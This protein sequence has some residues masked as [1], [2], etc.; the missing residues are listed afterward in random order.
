VHYSLFADGFALWMV[1]LTAILVTS[2]IWIGK[3]CA[4][5]RYKGFAAL[6]FLLEGALF[7]CFL[8]SDAVL[9]FL[10]FELLVPPAALLI[11]VFG[12]AGR[13]RAA[14]LF[15]LYTLLGSAPMAIALWALA[16]WT[17]TT[18]GMQ[19]ATALAAI[20]PEKV[21]LLFFAFALAFAVKTPLFPFHGWQ[22]EAYS[23][24]PA[25]VTALLSGAMAK[26]GVFGFLRWTMPI[27]PNEVVEY[28][29]L[30]I[31]L[32]L[33]TVIYGALVA[34]RQ[35]DIKRILAFSSLSHLGLTVVGAFTLHDGAIFGVVV[36]MVAHGFSAG[37]LF[38][39]AG[40]PERWNGT[41]NIFAFG[42]LASQS[43]RFS[44]LFM[45]ACL[46]A[47]AVPGTLGFVGEFLIL[48]GIWQTFGPIIA[49]AA[50]LGAIL[51]A[52][53]TL[54]M[55]QAMLF[56]KATSTGV[57]PEIR[58]SEMVAIFPLIAILF[59]LGF[60][61][62][63]VLHSVESTLGQAPSSVANAIPENAPNATE[64]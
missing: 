35:T 62:K 20:A 22:A 2:V 58:K 4:G 10:F 7:G 30:F 5:E 64:R 12:G 55:V 49:L 29:T 21:T 57:G 32:G 38:L 50:G 3:T 54:R 6:V 13:N 9:F 36:M 33:A 18:D 15:A 14:I 26:V 51:S 11:S 25:P 56:G 34:M 27:F 43:P 46:A 1:L 44:L 23:E 53:Y 41:R 45:L 17:G 8:A 39:L 63:L 42:G 52:A 31:L 19:I 60:A 48:Q 61:P 37:A 24:A 28:G 47:V 40:I 59:V 16:T